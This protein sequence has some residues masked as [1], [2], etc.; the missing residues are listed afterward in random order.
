MKKIKILAFGEILFD[1]FGEERKIG[2]APFNFAAHARR[3][4][5][6]AYLMSAVGLD[7]LGE[8]ALQASARHAVRAEYIFRSSRYGTGACQ[9]TLDGRGIP[10]Y[11]LVAPAAYDDIPCDEKVATERFDG[12][13]F[14]TLS[15][16]GEENRGTLDALVRSHGDREIFVDVNVREPFCKR[17]ALLYALNHATI[18]KISDEELPFVMCE[19][20]SHPSHDVRD[21][22]QRIAERFPNIRLLLLTCGADGSL[23]YEVQCG[24]FYSCPAVET[25]VSSTVGAGDSYAAS[26][27]VNYMNGVPLRECMEKA[28]AVSAYVVSKTEAIPE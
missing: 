28:S 5:A 12:L 15:L 3:A 1:V 16:R 24:Q 19:V 6:E 22:L 2:G 27:M 21:A 10:R 8:L 9:V 11:D 4:G 17:E 20:F 23:A 18:L 25:E 7:E 26:F 13:Y 14:G